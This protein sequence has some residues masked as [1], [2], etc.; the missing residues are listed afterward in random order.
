MKNYD[1]TSR[2]RLVFFYDRSIVDVEIV[3][4]R[5]PRTFTILNEMLENKDDITATSCLEQ[6]IMK[7]LAWRNRKEDI[8]PCG[9][10][11]DIAGKENTHCAYPSCFNCSMVFGDE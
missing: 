6:N 8:M 10:D 11:K 4:K 7:R 9:L 3:M 2:T 5:A 1:S